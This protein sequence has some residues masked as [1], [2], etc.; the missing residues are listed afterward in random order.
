MLLI[1]ICEFISEM[2]R[3]QKNVQAEGR[4]RRALGD[5]G[6]LVKAVDAGEPKNQIKANRPMTRFNCFSL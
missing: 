3:K 6:N 5:I 2:E 1:K 4:N